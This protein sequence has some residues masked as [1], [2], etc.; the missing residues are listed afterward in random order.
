MIFQ[1]ELLK[2]LKANGNR[3]AIENNHRQ[4]SYAQL[5]LNANK[6]TD[7]L[8]SLNL[9]KETVIGIQLQDRSDLISAIIGVVNARCIF[10]P[11]DGTLPQKRLAV[12]KEELDLK[13][14]ISPKEIAANEEDVLNTASLEKFYMEDILKRA[15]VKIISY[16]D[17]EENDSIYIY[18]TSGSTG[19]P[20]GII[21]KNCSLLQFVQWEISAFEITGNSRFS[22]F[23]SPYFDAFLRDVFVPLIAG[24]TVC[25]PPAEKEFFSAEKMLSWIDESK[26]NLIHC[27]PSLFRVVNQPFLTVDNFA[28]LKYVLLSGEKIIPSELVNWYTIFGARIQLVNLYG[29]TETTMIRACYKIRPEDV[30]LAKMPIGSP[31]SD[32]KL[33]V[34]NGGFKSCALL[35][36]G[37]LYIITK[38]TSKGYLNAPELTKEKFITLNEGTANEVIAFKTGDKARVLPDG[39]IDLIGREDRQVKVRGIRLELDEIENVLVQS[40]FIKNAVCIKHTS[41]NGDESLVVFVIKRET[42]ADNFNL[43]EEVYHYLKQQ[44]PDYM[45]PSSVVEMEEYPLLSNGKINFPELLNHL[46]KVVII[47]PVNETEVK[48]L[49]IW[50]EILGEKPISTEESFHRMGGNSLSIMRLIGRIYK[51]FNIRIS[52]NEIFNNLTIKKQADFIKRADKDSC[53]VIQTT[54]IKPGYNLSAAQERLY[55]NYELNKASTAFN[56][57]MAWEVDQE[58]DKMKIEGALKLLIE[59]HESLRTEFKFI[60]G[61]LLQ[62]VKDAVE[63]AI[64]EIGTNASEMRNSMQAFVK[65]FN[66]NEAPLIR[67]AVLSADGTKKILMLD[68]H[69]IVCDG[70]SQ[71]IILR[72]FLTFFKGGNLQPLTI[73]YKDYSEWEY[74]FQ[75]THEYSSHREFWLKQFETEFPRLELPTTNLASKEMTDKGESIG[76][77]IDKTIA[78][79]LI[80]FFREEEVTNFSGLFAVYL[81]FLSQ[82]TGQ[83]DIV[84]GINTSG[85]MQTEMEEVVGMFVKTLPIRFQLEAKS[86]F[87]HFAKK[88]HNHLIQAN[89]KQI[90]DLA[91]ILSELNNKRTTPVKTLFEAMFVFLDFEEKNGQRTE[92]KF[93][94]HEVETITSK[95]PI[96]L[97]AGE[98]AGTFNFRFEYLSSYFTKGDM[99]LF[100]SK[101]QALLEAISENIDQ[102]VLSLVGGQ[103][104]TALLVE[105]EI[106]FDF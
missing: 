91:D 97:F 27:V 49:S 2:S 59:R 54:E 18:F 92:N 62:V 84:I 72:D 11:I 41:E 61:K 31:I 60:N 33:L 46:N 55:Y 81:M 77:R 13:Y 21:G 29:A 105:D 4:I 56:L 24:G 12:I 100:I 14:I 44:L 7:L 106:D 102:P 85:R 83:E 3:I 22:Q 75:T 90:Y 25:I 30:T 34:T 47:E 88:V 78:T 63:F 32:T 71:A 8:L 28:S 66:L 93:K 80:G 1:K 101:F 76:F 98:D 86:T 82:L 74:A 36:P 35:V 95:Y 67:C 43:N 6:V 65:P 52:L 68:M 38:F 37:D 103:A 51:E 48:L 20:K 26:I 9:P 45:I 79:P 19:K 50:K 10:V 104:K 99:E 64:E 69:H 17:Y 57:P 58:V 94:N 39:M 89:S 53:F 15:E 5:L 23:V 40:T 87:R 42:I 96:T 16:P 73:Q 70:M